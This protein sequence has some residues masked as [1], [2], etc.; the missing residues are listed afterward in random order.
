MSQVGEG[1]TSAQGTLDPRGDPEAAERGDPPRPLPRDT[2]PGV[3]EHQVSGRRKRG[4]CLGQENWGRAHLGSA[5]LTW[6]P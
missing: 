4:G 1:L 3:T 5:E 2:L 6:A